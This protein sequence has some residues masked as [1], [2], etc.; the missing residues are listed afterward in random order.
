[1]DCTCTWTVH[2]QYAYLH[3]QAIAPWQ[4]STQ[5]LHVPCT[6]IDITFVMLLQPATIQVSRIQ[7]L[8]LISVDKCS[9]SCQQ[10]YIKRVHVSLSITLSCTCTKVVTGTI[11]PLNIVFKSTTSIMVYMIIYLFQLCTQNRLFIE[12]TQICLYLGYLQ[13]NSYNS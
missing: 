9:E 7:L 6:H 13:I 11:Q 5:A 4:T 8:C 3:V 2:V 1:M 12:Y 10:L